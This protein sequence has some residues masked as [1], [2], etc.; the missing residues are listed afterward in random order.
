[1]KKIV[2]AA[3][4]AVASLS[5]NAQVWVGGQVG[6]QSKEV[7]DVETTT[8]QVLPEIGYTLNDSWDLA[9]ALGEDYSKVKDHDAL[10][11][12]V[13]NPY[14]RYTFAKTGNVSFFLNMGFSIKTGD[15]YSANLGKTYADETEWGIGIAPGVK[16]DASD[17]VSLVATLGGLGY[18]AADD[19]HAFGFNANGNALQFGV[20]YHF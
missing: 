20:Q 14:A 10:S 16:F 7:N 11:S 17:K 2:L 4:V 9:I 12:F 13:V 1:M 3:F 5:A 15:F 18:T 19:D 6:F 8:F